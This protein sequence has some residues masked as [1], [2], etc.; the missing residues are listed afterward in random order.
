MPRSGYT[1]TG[2]TKFLPYP[3]ESQADHSLIC[4]VISGLLARS[5]DM[6]FGNTCMASIFH[7]I[8]NALI[9]DIDHEIDTLIDVKEKQ[10]LEDIALLK[11][12]N[13]FSYRSRKKIFP[14]I[15]AYR[16]GELGPAGDLVLEADFLDRILQLKYYE[17]ILKFNLQSLIQEYDILN[18]GQLKYFQQDILRTYF[19]IK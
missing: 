4:A 9:P 19:L 18:S 10:Q 13:D 6:D 15:H 12:A 17:K 7:H 8:H 1:R 11:I 2:K 14:I 16:Q 3:R 5:I